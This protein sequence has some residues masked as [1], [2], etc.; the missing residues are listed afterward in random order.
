MLALQVSATFSNLDQE[1]LLPKSNRFTMFTVWHCGFLQ[2]WHET[3]TKHI[4]H[5]EMSTFNTVCRNVPTFFFLLSWLRGLPDYSGKSTHAPWNLTLQNV[6][7]HNWINIGLIMWSSINTTVFTLISTKP[8]QIKPNHQ[9]QNK[10]LLFCDLV[11]LTLQTE[12]WLNVKGKIAISWT[13]QSNPAVL[14]DKNKKYQ[15]QTSLS[16][17]LFKNEYLVNDDNVNTI[18]VSKKH[19]KG[20]IALLHV[21]LFC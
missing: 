10:T 11:E 18:F 14:P 16:C 17:S 21:Y 2:V 1:V 19:V 5:S 3:D 15:Y 9:G 20:K 8:V 6:S 13:Q 4:F 7:H 12:H